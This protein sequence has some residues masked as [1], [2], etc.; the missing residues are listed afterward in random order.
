MNLGK[1][2][3]GWQNTL[4][5]TPLSHDVRRRAALHI[6]SRALNAQDRP[7]TVD[8]QDLLEHLGLYDP[9]LHSTAAAGA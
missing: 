6:A 3:A 7:A 8:C 2:N 9:A 5:I 4:S 1:D